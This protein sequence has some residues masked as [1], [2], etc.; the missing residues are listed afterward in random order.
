MTTITVNLGKGLVYPVDKS[1]LNQT[2]LD[3]AEYIGLKNILQDSH[4]AFTKKE[5]PDTYRELSKNAV[6]RKLA[7]LYNGE[8][9]VNTPSMTIEDIK[10]AMTIEELEAELKARKAAKKVA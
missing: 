10:K 1:R 2:V 6:D 9:R 8:L 4:A 7:A 5:F 3:H